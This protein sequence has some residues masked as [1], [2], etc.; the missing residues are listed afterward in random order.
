MNTL[1]VIKDSTDSAI[2]YIADEKTSQ[3]KLDNQFSEFKPVD[4]QLATNVL[5]EY[6]AFVEYGAKDTPSFIFTKAN[7]EDWF[8]AQ[9]E[10]KNNKIEMEERDDKQ[11]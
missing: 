1:N 9:V 10:I 2:C 7:S 3:F 6:G 8:I 4:Q 5:S 11:L